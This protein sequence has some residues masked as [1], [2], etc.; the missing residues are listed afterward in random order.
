MNTPAAHVTP[1]AAPAAAAAGPDM[2][3]GS[4]QGCSCSPPQRRQRCQAFHATSCSPPQL[5]GQ[6]RVR[7]NPVQL[8]G[9]CTPFSGVCSS[10]NRH[11]PD[12]KVDFRS[13]MGTWTHPV[14]APFLFL[15]CRSFPCFPPPP[16]LVLPVTPSVSLS[17]CLSA[18]T[19]FSGVC[20]C[21]KL[22]V[23]DDLAV[24]QVDLGVGWAH[25]TSFGRGLSCA[26]IPP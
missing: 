21:A 1:A 5:L 23:P 8:P 10:A 6:R 4:C 25:N 19:P 24:G 9:A 16:D 12:V 13:G 20:S 14:R 3:S 11:A 18:C 7:R 26:P 17:V 22:H 15:L 2:L